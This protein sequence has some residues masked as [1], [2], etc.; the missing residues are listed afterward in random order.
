MANSI[1]INNFP[2]TFLR[3]K[4]GAPYGVVLA[5]A[6]GVGWSVC[7]KCDRRKFSKQFA[8][9]IAINRANFK[10]ETRVLTPPAKIAGLVAVM[11]ERR[12]RYFKIS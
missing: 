6:L 12:K 2:K 1:T 5:T 7:A 3:D 4:N 8:Q 11:E 9:R 10:S